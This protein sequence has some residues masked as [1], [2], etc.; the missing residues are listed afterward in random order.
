MPDPKTKES[1]KKPKVKS[2]GFVLKQAASII[3]EKYQQQKERNAPEQKD[4]VHYATDQVER[5][6]KRTLRAA[7]AVAHVIRKKVKAERQLRRREKHA[8]NTGNSQGSS[9]SQ[10]QQATP[11][12]SPELL[13]GQTSAETVPAAPAPSDAAGNF[14]APVQEHVQQHIRQPDTPFAD[15]TDFHSSAPDHFRFSTPD[16][17]TVNEGLQGR[18]KNP[19]QSRQAAAQGR[20]K[21]IGDAKKARERK[22]EQQRFTTREQTHRV[23]TIG[24]QNFRERVDA[25]R[26]GSEQVL[27]RGRTDTFTTLGKSSAENTPEIDSILKR[28]K[29]QKHFEY[30]G[31][32]A[33]RTR[34]IQSSGLRPK[35][36]TSLQKKT[37]AKR[38]FQKRVSPAQKAKAAAQK[39]A[40][41]EMARKAAQQ[42]ARATK[43]AGKLTVRVVVA[44]GRAVVAAVRGLIAACS[45]VVGLIVL[46]CILLI[47]A[48]AASPFG[49]FFSGESA[50]EDSVPLSVAVGQISFSFN[51]TL[52]ELQNDETYDDVTVTGSAADWVEVI[53]VFA[54]KTAGS[55]DADATDVV[56]LDADRI[57]RLEA[58]FWDMTTISQEVREVENDDESDDEDGEKEPKR[59]LDITITAKSAEEMAAEYDFTEQQLEVLRELLANRAMIQDLIGNLGQ[60]T[61][62]AEAVLDRLPE[63]ITL[64]REAV[65]RAACSLVGKVGYF[66]GGKSYALGW[67]S[68][69]GQLLKVTAA[70]SVT[71]GT[72]RPYGLDCSGFV[73]WVFYNATG[74]EPIMTGSAAMQ[75]SYCTPISW[76]EALPGDLVFYADDS[77]VGIV[78]GYDESGNILIVHCTPS[79]GV[80]ITGREYFSAIG[81]PAY[82][83]GG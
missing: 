79:G 37:P 6:G 83:A 32:S 5:S 4:P 45:S 61:A 63:D 10:S 62:D 58:V 19:A 12:E 42:T 66:W 36:G 78:A 39:K 26:S 71:T 60:I 65:L 41:R 77:H 35:Q 40:R 75:H 55:D 67:D 73:T 38:I 59:V 64:E 76:S 53:A 31:S 16:S 48:I 68:R 51:Q 54:V 11:Q 9:Q 43:A 20:Q 13:P 44:V 74:G 70:G 17:R 46:V 34:Y 50:A 47:A 15:H 27:D 52:A 21:A 28:L 81:R 29:K 8:Q 82:F 49:I 3:R 72:Y 14:S 25:I 80:V 69:W 30:G 24:Q 57:D 33:G 1:A 2:S 23:E 18:E 22:V 56:I 7:E